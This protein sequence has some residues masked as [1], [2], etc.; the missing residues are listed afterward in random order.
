M[1]LDF[2]TA[3]ERWRQ[4]MRWP[5]GGFS[6]RAKS[7]EAERVFWKDYI[8]RKGGWQ[9]D[10]YSVKIADAICEIIGETPVD[11]ILELGPGWGNYTLRLAALCS[12]LTCVDISSDVLDY[13]HRIAKENG[14]KNIGTICEKWEECLPP[15]CSIVFAY[16]CFYRMTEIEYCLQKIDQSAQQLCIIGMGSGPEQPYIVDFEQELGLPVRYTRVNIRDL[17]DV[18]YGLGIQAACKTIPNE[19]DYSYDTFEELFT[20]AS[21]YITAPFD[22]AAVKRILE[23][24]Y[25]YWDGKYRC[26]H[27]FESALL[28]WRPKLV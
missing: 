13:I 12:R 21:Q 17:S 18:L 1:K 24:H 5:D 19:R 2:C 9:P 26:H 28:F 20:R 10:G 25:R 4:A 3:G 7:D 11:S 14:I 22:E 23:R 8:A 16:N 27:T 6:E 15:R